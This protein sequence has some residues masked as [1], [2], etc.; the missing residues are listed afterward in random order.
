MMVVIRQNPVFC[1]VGLSDLD[2]AVGGIRGKMALKNAGTDG[3]P[4]HIPLTI[5]LLR[6]FGEGGRPWNSTAHL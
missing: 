3:V 2:L 5:C 6:N 1:R 4:I